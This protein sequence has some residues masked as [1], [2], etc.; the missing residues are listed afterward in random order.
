[1]RDLPVI[2]KPCD[3]QHNSHDQQAACLAR[4]NGASVNMWRHGDESE[5]AFR[6]RVRASCSSTSMH[7]IVSYSRKGLLQTGARLSPEALASLN[8]FSSIPTLDA[9][10]T[11]KAQ[12]RLLVFGHGLP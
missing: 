6:D 9:R 12:S 2:F 5:D 4:C 10:A 3:D 11:A 1:M 8:G 7:M